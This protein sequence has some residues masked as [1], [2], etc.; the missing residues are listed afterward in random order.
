MLQE[1]ST[2][3]KNSDNL[4]REIGEEQLMECNLF[5]RQP[6]LHTHEYIVQCRHLG[7]ALSCW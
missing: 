2:L 4:L 6:W 1:T 5:T 3:D 7:T